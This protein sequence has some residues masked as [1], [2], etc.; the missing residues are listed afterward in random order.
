MGSELEGV[1]TTTG[2]GGR[3]RTEEKT[4][5]LRLTIDAYPVEESPEGTHG[6]SLCRFTLKRRTD[7]GGRESHKF[8]SIQTVSGPTDETLY[9]NRG[10]RDPVGTKRPHKDVQ[11]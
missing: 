5:G 10:H 3:G 2:F 6:V 8:F 1:H 11:W 9:S 4:R 7:Y